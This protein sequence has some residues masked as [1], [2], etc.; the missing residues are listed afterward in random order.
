VC[1]V[2][3]GVLLEASR[4]ALPVE[5]GGIGVRVYCVSWQR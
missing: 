5:N 1:F 4:Q 3:S 2:G